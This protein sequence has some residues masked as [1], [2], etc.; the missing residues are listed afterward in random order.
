MEQQSLLGE[1]YSSIIFQLFWAR[2]WL[3][4][5]VIADNES[6]RYPRCGGI[7][8]IDSRLRHRDRSHVWRGVIDSGDSQRAGACRHS[9]SLPYPCDINSSYMVFTIT[10]Q[11]SLTQLSLAGPDKLRHI[12]VDLYSH[13][14]LLYTAIPRLDTTLNILLSIQIK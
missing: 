7:R 13:A 6:G 8:G 12:K 3:A 14:F 5:A 1:C 9:T 11:P 4:D 2:T 10:W